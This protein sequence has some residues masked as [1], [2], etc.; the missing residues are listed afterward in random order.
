M[1]RRSALLPCLQH[2]AD[3]LRLKAA[4]DASAPPLRQLALSKPLD[5][6]DADMLEALRQER[7][8]DVM[9]A[10]AAGGSCGEAAGKVGGR[11]QERLESTG[12]VRDARERQAGRQAG[13]HAGWCMWRAPLFKAQE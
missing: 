1:L 9:D 10:L 2:I 6:F 5:A 3:T 11:W 12:K 7:L 13:R 4:M 8:E